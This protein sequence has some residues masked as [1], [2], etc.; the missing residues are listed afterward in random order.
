MRKDVVVNQNRREFLKFAAAG[1]A[2]LATGELVAAPASA[3]KP[4]KFLVFSD[5]HFSPG[6]WT[7]DNIEFLEKAI[8]R[9]KRERCEMIF[10]LGDLIHSPSRPDVQA[11]VKRL[12]T[13]G[14]PVKHVLGNHDADRGPLQLTMDLFNLKSG[15]Y[16][17]DVGGFRF[18]AL[19]ANYTLV[20]GKYVHHDRQNYFGWVKTKP[21]NVM[22]PE[23]IEWLK[24]CVDSSPH[25]CVLMSHHSFERPRSS[26]GV[27]NK[28]EV[29]KVIADAN[30]KKPRSVM[31]SMCGHYHVG[32]M[33]L[34][35]NVLY[36]ELNGANFFSCGRFHKC[37]PPE[38]V[39]T[40]PGAPRNIAWQDP[41]SAVVTLWP[42]GRIRIEGQ[43]SDYF[44]GVST[45]KAGFPPCDDVGRFAEPL[46]RSV[47]FRLGPFADA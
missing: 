35:D 6:E 47:D 20:D 2:A 33:S 39:K 19:D 38:Y 8:D 1:G 31:M 40:H 32:N 10:Q 11:Y 5:I 28:D 41:L 12:N 34:C 30:A 13:C 24:E 22:P 43:K 14:V 25:P 21:F 44:M 4:F 17:F 7:N 16:H 15:Y 26:E 18:I 29:R 46:I 3:V 45:E 37:F 42:N 23:E 9:A 36:W 27:W